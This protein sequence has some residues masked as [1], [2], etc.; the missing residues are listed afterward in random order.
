MPHG[1][2]WLRACSDVVLTG[3]RPATCPVRPSQ[4]LSV[5]CVDD[6][7][8]RAH[9]LRPAERLDVLDWRGVARQ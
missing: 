1:P 5:I 3:D 7:L 9:V 2:P 8:Q 6:D 4:E